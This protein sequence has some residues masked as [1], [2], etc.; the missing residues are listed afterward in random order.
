MS[1]YPEIKEQ[2]YHEMSFD[3]IDKIRQ[4][5]KAKKLAILINESELLLYLNSMSEQHNFQLRLVFN[6]AILFIVCSIVFIFINWKISP[7]LFIAGMFLQGTHR[8][9]AR[10]YIYRECKENRVFLKFALGVGLVKLQK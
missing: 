6:I 8:K 7:F 10:L 2:K 1:K 5:I 9:L 3:E 4:S